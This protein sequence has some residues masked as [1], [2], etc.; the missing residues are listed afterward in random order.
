MTEEA[1]V[2]L[3]ADLWEECERRIKGTNFESVEE[4]VQFVVAELLDGTDTRGS[5]GVERSENSTEVMDRLKS[6]GYR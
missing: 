6:L 3:P 1:S 5:S 2:R 4:Y